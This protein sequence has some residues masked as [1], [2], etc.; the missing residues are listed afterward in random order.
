MSANAL[1]QQFVL[2]HGTHQEENAQSIRKTG[3]RAT[4][5]HIMPAAWPTLTTNR[6]Q[7]QRYGQ[8]VVEVHMTPE[9]V[10][11]HL[12]PGQP[13]TA[14]GFDATAYSIR[15]PIPARLVK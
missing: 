7:A 2:Y 9:Q 10:D 3:M 14:Y 13:H 8:H 15:R 6:D 11:T 5:G 12:W 1:G 4:P